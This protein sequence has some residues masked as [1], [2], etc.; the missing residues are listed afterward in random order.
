M[1]WTIFP[2]KPALHRFVLRLYHT[3]HGVSLSLQ[4]LIRTRPFMTFY[5]ET[6]VHLQRYI[7]SLILQNK[8]Y[9]IITFII[10]YLLLRFFVCRICILGISFNPNR[11]LEIFSCKKSDYSRLC[12]R[13][14]ISILTQYVSF[15]LFQDKIK[16][17]FPNDR[18][19][20]NVAV[21]FDLSFYSLPLILFSAF[22]PNS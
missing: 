17:K 12:H 20:F 3:P 15:V 2:P 8:S 22:R 16:A 11:L 1:S 13:Y 4:C 19:G 10:L 14:S 7:L 9:K 18:F 6:L 5:R 21:S